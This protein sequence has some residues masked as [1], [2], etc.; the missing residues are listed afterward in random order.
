MSKPALAR[1]ATVEN[2]LYLAG[3][4]M[5]LWGDYQFTALKKAASGIGRQG[6]RRAVANPLSAFVRGLSRPRQIELRNSPLP[7]GPPELDDHI[8]GLPDVFPY[9]GKGQRC[10][11][12]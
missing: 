9:L 5:F 1:N 6:Q 4:P 8:D 10:A 7:F 3:N 12:L 2:F 11:S